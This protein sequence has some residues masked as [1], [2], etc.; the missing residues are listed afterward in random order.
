MAETERK[1]ADC[2]GAIYEAASGGQTWQPVAAQ[3]CEIMD[4]QS[5]FLSLAVEMGKPPIC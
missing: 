3:L 5:V 4:A 2:V 1:L